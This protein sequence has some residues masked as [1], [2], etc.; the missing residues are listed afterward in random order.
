MTDSRRPRRPGR[1]ARPAPDR[2]REKVQQRGPDECWPWTGGTTGDYGSFRV[3][4]DRVVSAHGYAK[5]LATGVT[6]PTDLMPMHT[7]KT[8]NSSL[9][10]NPDHIVYAPRNTTL[11]VVRG[12]AHPCCRLSDNQVRTIR[13]RALAG[14]NQTRLAAEYG[15]TPAYVSSIKAGRAR[16]DA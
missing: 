11:F 9:C 12:E 13:V 10:C 4:T 15:I 5:L 8:P 1:K 16:A 6:C 7:C 3:T 14:E 2:F